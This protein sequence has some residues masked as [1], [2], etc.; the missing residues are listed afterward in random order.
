MT[1]TEPTTKSFKNK[2]AFVQ[3]VD[4]LLKEMGADYTLT[5]TI[6]RSKSGEFSVS[7]VTL[8]SEGT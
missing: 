7:D 4:N 2:E 5:M 8:R 3:S 1:K 6:R